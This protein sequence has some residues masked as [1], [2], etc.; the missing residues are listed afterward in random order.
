MKDKNKT[1]MS[2]SDVGE[3]QGSEVR[4][5]ALVLDFEKDK[6]KSSNQNMN[7]TLIIL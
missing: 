4:E 1:N 7:P 5:D 2:S 6:R 3:C